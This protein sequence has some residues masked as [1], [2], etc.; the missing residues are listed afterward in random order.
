MHLIGTDLTGNR[1][2]RGTVWNARDVTEAKRLRDELRH[3]ATHDPL[4]GLANRALLEQRL[5]E[6]D[7]ANPV[8]VLLLDLDGLNKSMTCTDTTPAIACSSPSRNDWPRS[9]VPRAP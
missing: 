5:R 8:G 4:T 6:A 7:A 1:N 9:W 3:Q 2:V